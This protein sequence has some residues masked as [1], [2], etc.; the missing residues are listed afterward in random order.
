MTDIEMDVDDSAVCVTC[1]P[2]WNLIESAVLDRVQER[3]V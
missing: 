1:V 3:K 2:S